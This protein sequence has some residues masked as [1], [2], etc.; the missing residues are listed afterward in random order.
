MWMYE[1]SVGGIS[2][3]TKSKLMFAV[4]NPHGGQKVRTS[5]VVLPV[6]DS[7]FM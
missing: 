6:A 4:D 1:I 5:R 2:E 3:Y 7:I